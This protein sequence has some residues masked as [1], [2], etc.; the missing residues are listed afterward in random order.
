M[1]FTGW[2]K[3][4][5]SQRGSAAPGRSLSRY[6]SLHRTRNLDPDLVAVRCLH[7]TAKERLSLKCTG[8]SP[9]HVVL[10]L[11]HNCFWNADMPTATSIA[12]AWPKFIKPASL[13]LVSC[14]WPCLHRPLPRGKPTLPGPDVA[15]TWTMLAPTGRFQTRY[16]TTPDH[17]GLES[18]GS[19]TNNG[20][21]ERQLS[22]LCH[23]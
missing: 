3:A 14:T 9:R 15:C 7:C 11:V 18:S 2:V 20:S 12:P 1:A 16:D 6:T 19:Q 4:D 10:F 17:T 21:S 13:R 8:S 5:S 23:V 22:S